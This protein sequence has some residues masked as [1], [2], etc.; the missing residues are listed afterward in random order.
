MPEI[1]HGIVVFREGDEYVAY[2]SELDV[3]SCGR[4][5]EQARRKAKMAVRL[6]VEEAQRKGTS[7]LALAECGSYG[8]RHG[9]RFSGAHH[10]HQ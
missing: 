10:R 8:P 5:I 9:R 4:D 6:F 3:S 1:E 2:C 7:E